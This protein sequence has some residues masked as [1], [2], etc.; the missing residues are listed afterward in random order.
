MN[1]EVPT[2]RGFLS[3]PAWQREEACRFHQICQGI[4]KRIDRGESLRRAVAYFTA[5]YRSGRHMKSEPNRLFQFGRST[6]QRKYA[7]WKDDPRPEAL[8]RRYRTHWPR[9]TG[10]RK[11]RSVAGPVDSEIF[12]PV[13]LQRLRVPVF[14]SISEVLDSFE[15][16]FHHGRRIPG[17]KLKDARQRYN[18]LWRIPGMSKPI[19]ERAVFRGVSPILRKHV[20]ELLAAR[21]RL[22]ARDEKIKKYLTKGVPRRDG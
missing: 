9:Q 17:V 10:R 8:A 6:L 16:D 7:A 13:F 1:Q 11:R 3:L 14:V 20:I 5:L 18:S 15:L 19:L 4:Q 2:Q 12:R 22:Y 21:K